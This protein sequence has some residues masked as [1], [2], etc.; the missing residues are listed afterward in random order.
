MPVGLYDMY[1]VIAEMSQLV[2]TLLNM[3]YWAEV[4]WLASALRFLLDAVTAPKSVFV[5]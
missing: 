5:L 3:Y 4:G 1:H 2:E